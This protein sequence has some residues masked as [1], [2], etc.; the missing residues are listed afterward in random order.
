MGTKTKTPLR[1]LL[2]EMGINQ[3][4][5]AKKTDFSQQTISRAMNG[6]MSSTVARKIAEALSVDEESL[7]EAREEA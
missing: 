7:Y 1:R 6:D 5:L 2:F 4:E 3:R